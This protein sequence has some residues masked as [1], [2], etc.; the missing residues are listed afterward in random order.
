[1]KYSHVKVPLIMQMEY[2][3]CGAAS[4]A[5]ILAYYGKYVPLEQV[6][7]DCGVSRDGSRA[8]N[9]VTAAENYGLVADG[10]RYSVESAMTKAHFPCIIHW[11][12]A[13]F[14]VL[15]GFGKNKAYLNDPGLGEITVTMEE[16]NRSFTGI[17]LEFSPGEN[18]VR[19]GKAPTVSGYLK[20]HAAKYRS[21]LIFLG[22]DALAVAIVGLMV[23]LFQRVFSDVVLNTQQPWEGSFLIML[24]LLGIVEL[25]ADLLREI[26]IYRIQGDMAI[27][28]NTRFFGHLLRLPMEFYQ[29]RSAGDLISRLTMNS[30]IAELLVRKITPVFIQLV[31]VVIFFVA[32]LRQSVIAAFLGAGALI[33]NIVLTWYLA[34]FTLQSQQ[35][36]MN[37]QMQMDATMISGIE[38]IETIKSSGVANGY[39]SRWASQQAEVNSSK[40]KESKVT[41]YL[42]GFSTFL[43][44]LTSALVLAVA[45]WSILHGMTTVGIILVLQALVQKMT[46][47]AAMLSEVTRNVRELSTSIQKVEDVMEYGEDPA[48]PV[49]DLPDAAN[50]QPLKGGI[51]FRHVTFGY[52]RVAPPL[53]DDFS[54]TVE[55]GQRVAFVGASGSG[56]STVAKLATGA[57]L[58]WSGQVLFDGIDR[59]SIPEPVFTDGVSVVSQESSLF[60][61]SV[62]N[63]IR[64]WDPGIS[65]AA[66]VSAATEACIHEEII[67]HPGG[68]DYIVQSGGK[69]FSGGQCQRIA[70]ARAL[71]GDPRILVMDEATSALDAMTEYQIM[72][73]IKARGIT[74]IIVAHRLST[75]R[76]CDKIIVLDAGKIVEQG[77]HDELMKLQGKYYSLVS[78]V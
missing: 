38:M 62:A 12:M 56:K 73:N 64:M 10:Y 28:S 40:T 5:M 16:F 19:D 1:M 69:N 48:F 65:S 4:L 71:A 3:E 55:P 29:Q 30:S 77:T 68:Y 14:V 67:T 57:A 45:G 58:P 23:P 59:F 74:M 75:V 32:L 72:E 63:N 43:Q 7:R 21:A 18:F 47:P 34:R 66:I 33:A 25:A 22:L 15:R 24:V 26:H 76:G 60:E 27:R 39:F 36:R 78:S 51:E 70:I 31:M 8:S 61:D 13:H 11:N 46:A 49:K 35:Q 52:S 6:R 2:V 37:S 20:T 54:F 53:L 41:V 9:L 17:L 44:D 50:L 42:A